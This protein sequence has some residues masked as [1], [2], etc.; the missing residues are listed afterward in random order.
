MYDF[1]IVG[2][3]TA[4]CLV[5]KNLSLTKGAPQVLLIESGGDNKNDA[6]RVPGKRFMT[7]LTPGMEKGYQSTPQPQLN[8]RSLACLRGNGL[9]GS[10]AVNFITYTRGARDNYD[11]WARQTGDEFWSW[12]RCKERFIKLEGLQQPHQKYDK[13]FKSDPVN[14]L[15]S[16][17]PVKLSH[18]KEWERD[19]KTVVEAAADYGYPINLD[20]N[21]GNPIGTGVGPGT[22]QDGLRTT[23][24]SAY[25]GS[26]PGNLHILT[27]ANVTQII[28]RDQLAIGVRTFDKEYYASR[29]IILCAGAIDTPKLLLLSGVGPEEDLKK[30]GIPLVHNLPGVGKNLQDHPN[31]PYSV[32]VRP[33]FTDR[34]LFYG[35]GEAL[36]DAEDQWNSDHTGPFTSVACSGPLG[37]AKLDKIFQTPQ[38]QDL[39]TSVKEYLRL[40]TIPTFE[41]IT[42]SPNLDPERSLQTPTLAGFVVLLN[43]LSRGTVTIQSADPNDPPVC[44]LGFLSNPFDAFVFSQALREFIQFLESPLMKKHIVSMKSFGTVLSSDLTDE[45]ILTYIKTE[46]RSTSHMSGTTKMGK[47]DDSSAVVDSHGRILGLHGI[48]VADM[49]IAPI[50]PS[51]HSQAAAYLIGQ[52]IV[53]RLTEEYKLD[54]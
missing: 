45:E 29:E 15:G 6:A 25:L 39:D 30:H 52:S 32:E 51:A 31:T 40:P 43:A 27:A 10:S 44:D 8:D 34:H 16:E 33:D 42:Q 3:G 14:G 4:G 13:L 17:G 49:S 38:F 12:E 48:R 46:L 37:F 19:I 21:S 35:N 22:F 50:L 11:E 53:E 20:Y 7:F 5:A 2:G 28:F 23:S 36:K 24:S 1:I 9:G 26:V 41:W 47:P 54:Q 18:A